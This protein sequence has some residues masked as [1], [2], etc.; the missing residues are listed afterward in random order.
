MIC[1]VGRST[2]HLFFSVSLFLLEGSRLRHIQSHTLTS[3]KRLE[4]VRCKTIHHAVQADVDAQTLS[5][6]CGHAALCHLIQRHVKLIREPLA[7]S[8]G[9]RC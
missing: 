2:A 5:L 7:T 4:R 6:A 1:L 8:L 9:T 3:T